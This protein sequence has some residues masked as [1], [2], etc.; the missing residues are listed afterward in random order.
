MNQKKTTSPN[1]FFSVKRKCSR[2]SLIYS[3]LA[4][5]LNTCKFQCASILSLQ[6]FFSCRTVKC[7]TQERLWISLYCL[8]SF[9]HVFGQTSGNSYD[10][11]YSDSSLFISTDHQLT[12][13]HNASVQPIG[14]GLSDA[15]ATIGVK[16]DAFGIDASTFTDN[17][18]EITNNSQDA[19]ITSVVYDM[20]TGFIPNL[21]FD[22]NGTA[23]DLGGKTFTE[24]SNTGGD[25]NIDVVSHTFGAPLGDGGF[26]KLTILF[27][28]FEPG[29]TF[30]FSADQDPISV[31]GLSGPGPSGSGAVSG[32]EQV[33]ATI[34]VTFDDGSV[35]TNTLYNNGRPPGAI[36]KIKNNVQTAPTI[37]V[38]GLSSPS[39]TDDPSQIIQ[40]SGGPANGSVSLLQVEAGIFLGDN[41]YVPAS[42]EVNSAIVV[43]RMTGISL[44]A[45]GSADIPVTLTDAGDPATGFNY[46]IAAVEDG[47]D[48]GR[49][50]NTLI[51]KYEEGCSVTANLIA[52]ATE[53]C[54]SDM[55][56]FTASGGTMYEFFVNDISQGAPSTMTTFTSSALANGDEVKV[57]V[58]NGSNCSA[59]SSVITMSVHP[60]PDPSGL[61]F[62]VDDICMGED[63]IGKITNATG[64]PDGD[65]TFTYDL[66][67]G[68]PQNVL[69]TITNGAGSFS[70]N[71][72]TLSAYTVNLTKVEN[73]N[74][75][76]GNI[77]G[78]DD[79]FV[80]NEPTISIEDVEILE[81]DAGSTISTFTV[82]LPSACTDTISVN[83]ATVNGTATAETDF[84]PQQGTLKFYPGTLS[85]DIEITVFG[86]TDFEEDELFFINLS[87]AVGA[88]I[89]DGQGIGTILND[90]DNPDAC[91]PG[92]L[93]ITNNPTTGYIDPGTYRAE[94][95]VSDGT[96]Q[97]GTTVNFYASQRIDLVIDIIDDNADDPDT[98]TGFTVEPTG[99]FNAQIEA[100][101]LFLP[102]ASEDEHA[103]T[104]RTNDDETFDATRSLLQHLWLK[105]EP[106][107]ATDF[108]NIRFHLSEHDLVNI[109]LL[110]QMG[111]Q[112][113]FPIRQQD[114]GEG[115]HNLTIYTQQLP[116]GM[117]F[118]QLETST[119]RIAEKVIVSSNR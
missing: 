31:E 21:V 80:I 70:I 103:L 76:F 25:N 1:L 33:G 9:V 67:G 97:A 30:G 96:V 65:Y 59:T 53:I 98:I 73:A 5:W 7:V 19:N 40:V 54:A 34:T 63:A 32:L 10:H 107:P 44:D 48:F 42:F 115:E 104:N 72:L 35:F 49:T 81:G 8:L 46:F 90:D 83:Y 100:C 56:T 52:S 95:I 38:V 37:Q 4:F 69:V 58:S 113:P 77:Q 106:N 94:I 50:S 2:W 108:M 12:F 116:T 109:R 39:T 57:V 26:Q 15:M 66:N 114:F 17:S 47:S 84:Q 93:T 23:G 3:F 119:Q 60:L 79:G 41:G 87:S 71:E 13:A 110:N 43:N 117:Y 85:E 36:S 11:S 86:D 6:F 105:V 82:T 101:Q 29:E 45:N 75:C 64:L 68:A 24:D 20:T 14:A 102:L 16:A 22:P 62:Q 74:G 89:L 51:L 99:Q 111:Q 28:D 18:F 112:L 88:T 27:E 55:V 91:V 118:I 92:T 61:E 78:V